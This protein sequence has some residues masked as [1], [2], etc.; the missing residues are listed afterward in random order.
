MPVLADGSLILTYSL[1][2][3]KH[4]PGNMMAVKNSDFEGIFVLL[5]IYVG[6]QLS[7][8]SFSWVIVMFQFRGIVL[9]S[10]FLLI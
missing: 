8:K 6:D 9:T 7:E 2:L 1:V 5:F 3:A 4:D 10:W